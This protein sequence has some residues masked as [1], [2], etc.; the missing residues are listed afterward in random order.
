MSEGTWRLS[1]VGRSYGSSLG[2]RLAEYCDPDAHIP[3]RVPDG[4]AQPPTPAAFELPLGCG[5]YRC[6]VPT[7]VLDV[8]HELDMGRSGAVRCNLK[9][10]PTEPRANFSAMKYRYF[11]PRVY[12]DPGEL[13]RLKDYLSKRATG[14]R[15][16]RWR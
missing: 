15:L 6:L 3:L 16:C 13:A 11:N 10:N 9:F 7:W 12:I 5:D 4:H 2:D 8:E 14:A 1:V